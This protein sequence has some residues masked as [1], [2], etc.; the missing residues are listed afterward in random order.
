MRVITEVELREQYKEAEFSSYELPAGTRLTP[1]AAQYLSERRITLIEHSSKG[2][3][4]KAGLNRARAGYAEDAKA[5]SAGTKGAYQVLTTGETLD[6]K[7]E[8]MTHLRGRNLVVKNHPRIKYRGKLDTLEAIIIN[9]ILDAEGYGCRELARDLNQLLDYSRQMMKAEVLEKPLEPL[10]FQGMTPAEI[11][12]HSHYPSKYYGV[13]HLTPQP[14]HGRLLAQLNF[15][16]TQCR[17]L[18]VAAVEAFDDITGEDQ[19]LD[20]L[21]AVNRFSSLVYIMMLQL[22][23]GHYKVGC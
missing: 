21:Q 16:R 15:L 5:G 22:T 7:P 20:I 23:S 19:R 14:C 8:F 6:E 11:R 18:E 12:E 17:E 9:T 2:T 3:A 13:D 10:S 1:S 4:V